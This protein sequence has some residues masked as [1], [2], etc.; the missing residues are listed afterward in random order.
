MAGS[1]IEI[2]DR[3]LEALSRRL[4]RYVRRLDSPRPMMRTVAAM[5]ES[6]TKRRIH[7]EKESPQGRDWAK[8]SER[9]ARTR[10]SEHSL[11]IGRGDLEDSIANEYTD[12]IAQAFTDREYGAAQQF[13]REEINLPTRPYFGLSKGNISEIEETVVD[14]LEGAL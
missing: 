2:D 11:L 7:D 10:R 14:W 5:L 12:D 6:Q 9:Y 8:W 13:G 4:A 3:E 1:A